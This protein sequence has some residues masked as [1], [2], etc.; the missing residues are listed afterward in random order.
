MTN[1]AVQAN[2]MRDRLGNVD[3]IRDLLFGQDKEQIDTR[4][5]QLEST[6]AELRQEMGDRLTQ[7][8]EEFASELKSN[9]YALE[10]KIQYISV[11]H[12]DDF[13]EAKQN[14]EQTQKK[15]NEQVTSIERTLK[16]QA[17]VLQQTIATSKET[18]EKEMHG[19]TGRIQAE[20]EK[21]FLGLQDQKVSRDELA[22]ILFDVC[23]KVKKTDFIREVEGSE[24]KADLLLP[25]QQS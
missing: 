17:D 24:M 25:E 3:Q 5:Q 19:I 11:T 23:M 7:L 16:S 13:T 4:L 6:I 1:D 15:F 10:K 12:T 9:S 8:Q 14:L 22:E 20:L 2:E 18:I 21:H